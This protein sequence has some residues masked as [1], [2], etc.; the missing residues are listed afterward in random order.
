MKAV[1]LLVAVFSVGFVALL[2]LYANPLSLDEEV[3]SLVNPVRPG[4]VGV[5]TVFNEEYPT[6]L[7]VLKLPR[8]TKPDKFMATVVS[9][10][11][12]YKQSHII[13]NAR[14]EALSIISEPEESKIPDLALRE[15]ISLVSRCTIDFKS[16]D[17]R[18]LH[19]T[20]ADVP[21]F[22]ILKAHP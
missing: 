20:N 7:K 2:P 21:H 5:G 6:V 15:R 18:Y 16:S 9:R 17:P 4:L 1:G 19:S 10:Q 11:K 8:G 3:H 12:Q 22:L 13:E 14:G